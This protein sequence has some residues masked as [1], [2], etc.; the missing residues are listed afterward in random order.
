M[1][2]DEIQRAILRDVHNHRVSRGEHPEANPAY[3]AK[4][5]GI[6]E[7]EAKRNLK[8]LIE[9]GALDGTVKGVIGG[10]Y[11]FVEDITA[12]GSKP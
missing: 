12:N 3:Y 11:F 2:P 6:T 7:I 8:H 4:E 1:D 10:S 5:L 9:T